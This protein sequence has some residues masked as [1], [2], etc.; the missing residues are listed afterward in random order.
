M[1]A[2]GS[3]ALLLALALSAYTLVA[4]SIALRQ[5]ATGRYGRLAP[6]RLAETARR[7]GI[8][9]FVAVAAAAFAL[10]WAAFTNDFSVS[11]ILHHSNRDLP[12]PYKFATLWSGQEGS[13]LLWAFLLAAYGFVL[14]LRHRTD[15]KLFAY[16]ST[17]LA[18]IQ[19]FFLMLLNFVAPPFAL[20]GG[21]IPADGFGLNPLLQYPEMVIHPPMLYLGYVGFSVP[22]AF[23]LGAL[24]MRYPGEKWIQITRRW[25][26]VTWL[27]LTFGI[28][29]GAHWAYSVLGWG[30]YWGWDPVE[31][32]SL[33][34]WLTGT[35]FLHSVMMQEKR[36]M[37]KKW[38]VWLI[39][40]TFL[41]TL[42][43]TDLTRS[44]LV[45]SV[46]AFAQS[47]IGGWFHAFMGIS[48]V[49]CAYTFWR[50]R[51]HLTADHQI[52]S[53]AS[54]ESSFLFNNIILLAACFTVL[55]GTLFP[56]LSEYAQGNRV[57]VGPPFYNRV[58]V[59]IGVFLMML[60][61]VGPLL[62]WRTGSLRSIRRNLARPVTAAGITAVLL[63]VWGL[64]PWTDEGSFYAYTVWVFAM[65]VAVAILSEFLRGAQVLS[66]QTGRNLL[67]STLLLCQRNTRRYG[68]YIIHL[69]VV[70]IFIGFAGSAFNQSQEREMGF[71]DRMQIG[72]YTLVA[73]S[74]TQDSNPNYDSEYALLD[75]YRHGKLVTTLTPSKRFYPASQQTE[76]IVANHSTL[77]WDLYTVY[78]GKNADTGQ[79]VLKIFLN[80]LVAWIWIGVLIVVAGTAVALAPNRITATVSVE[81]RP[82]PAQGSLLPVSGGD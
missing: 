76:T 66:R 33:M 11:Y 42:L 65:F 50:Q 18:A 3:Y 7:S 37:M 17:I 61:G 34:P 57:T 19:L 40:S 9:S 26:M 72:P 79:P 2:F 82:R 24:M 44:G 47:S 74:F 49:V 30:G 71:H 78:A 6:E 54:R 59:P 13:L 25:T 80:P 56:I 8:A 69:G 21:T 62:A 70:I 38:N 63:V 60:T 73:E 22:F 45:Q 55:W 28:F 36:G 53:L 15:V 14:R 31:N 75:V 77:A 32:A 68:G 20:V 51:A 67:R 10:I 46:H 12:G 81:A 16:A 52:E 1:P 4:G 27:F 41:L 58:A 48:F 5:L 29:L 39:F 23:A 43:G 35:A 64:R